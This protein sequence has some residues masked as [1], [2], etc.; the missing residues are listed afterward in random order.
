VIV[1]AVVAVVVLRRGRRGGEIEDRLDTYVAGQGPSRQETD[2]DEEAKRLARLT[3]GLNEALEKRTFGANIATQLAQASVKLTVTE[4]LIMR[5]ISIVAV[6][7]LA[8]LLFRN[9]LFLTG[10]LGG[11]IV[12]GVVLKML[13]ARRLKQFNDQLGDA[14]NL[15]VNSIRTG[16]SVA[17]AM[18]VVS[19]DMPPPIAEEFQRV[20]LEIGLGVR[21]D[22]AMNHMLRRVDSPDLDLFVTAINVQHEVGGNLAEFL[23]IISETI[24]E[25]VRIQGEIKTLTSQGQLTGIVISGLP[26]ALTAL[27]YMMNREYMGRMFTTPCGLIMVGGAVLIIGLGFYAMQQMIKIEV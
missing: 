1:I 13:K 14:I 6:T 27:L 2:I 8:W 25:R 7:G 15:M 4:Y 16:Y 17:Q 18:E 5:V 12:P 23:E 11:L 22:E 21:V 3:E 19:N 20:V 26:F 24:R 9:I 10:I